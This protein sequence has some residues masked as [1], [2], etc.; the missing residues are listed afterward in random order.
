MYL[1]ESIV[2]GSDGLLHYQFSRYL[3][4]HPENAFNHWAKPLFTLIM[5]VPA[6]GGFLFVQVVN[7]L[8]M[9]I[10]GWLVYRSATV[11][12]LK[13]SGLAPLFLGLGNAVTY[14]V[15]GALTEPLFILV[16]SWSIYAVLKERWI[17][18]YI[19]L[20]ASWFVRPEAIVIISVFGIYGIAKG[21]RLQ[22]LWG[23]LIPALY[24]V[25][26]VA[27]LGL[28]WT[29][30]ITDQPYKAKSG[31]YGEGNWFYFV[32]RWN[33]ITPFITL[34]LAFLASYRIFSK[35]DLRM[36]LIF[37]TG[38]GIIFLHSFL[39]AYGLRGS[40]GLLRIL[41]TSLPALALLSV[42]TLSRIQLWPR[43]IAASASLLL[44]AHFYSLNS[45]PRPMFYQE[46]IARK[47][48]HQLEELE[49]IGPDSRVVSQYATIAFLLDLDPFDEERS[50][51]MWS[52]SPNNPTEKLKSGDVIIWEN[53]VANR[54]GNMPYSALRNSTNLEIIDSIFVKQA[55]LSIV[56][57]RVAK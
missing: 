37:L 51:K 28:D 43:I 50:M 33:Q 18:L 2:D 9:L 24:T 49:A 5:S 38:F 14:V 52:I 20:G 17:L 27:M 7:A 19:L 47:M 8:F 34:V 36:G 10:S 11:L 13:F 54:E 26:G 45:F 30:I 1:Q 12:Q 23:L 48:V 46:A 6:Q 31:Y 39:W 40:A 15:L 57:F 42:Y 56:S 41:T 21:A 3:F 25:A 22:V 44:C 53:I 16:F 55:S 32:E 29:W 4:N 35:K